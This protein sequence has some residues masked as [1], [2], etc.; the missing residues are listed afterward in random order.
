MFDLS[1]VG[2]S[3]SSSESDMGR[4]A[5]A[6]VFASSILFAVARTERASRI[7]MMSDGVIGKKGY[8]AVALEEQRYLKN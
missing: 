3:L 6:S 2:I 8:E 4:P 1:T 7:F 5:A